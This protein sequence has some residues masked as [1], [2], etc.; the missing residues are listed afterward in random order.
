MAKYMLDMKGD[1]V[2]HFRYNYESEGLFY[3]HNG[4][5]LS[6][7]NGNSGKDFLW[8]APLYQ[9]VIEWL[10]CTHKI[11]IYDYPYPYE[12]RVACKVDFKDETGA[13]CS[14]ELESKEQAIEEA[15]NLI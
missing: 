3:N 1:V 12:D 13:W 9:Q 8:S 5:D 4:R 15:L 2:P 6:G 10:K 11:Y 7:L 14:V